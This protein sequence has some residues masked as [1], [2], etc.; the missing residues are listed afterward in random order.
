M[1]QKFYVTPNEV[2]TKAPRLLSGKSALSV[3]AAPFLTLAGLT[4]AGATMPSTAEA[5][6]WV[7][8]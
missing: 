1:P 2:S 8:D 5:A 4:F 3:L 7:L 6:T